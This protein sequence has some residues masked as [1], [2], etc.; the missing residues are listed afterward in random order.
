[1][2]YQHIYHAGNF[3]DVFKHCV[4]IALMEAFFQKSKPIT[5]FETH[6]GR[7][8]YDLLSTQAQKNP[9]FREGIEKLRDTSHTPQV[10]SWYLDTIKKL[11][12][13]ETLQKIQ[14]YPGSPYLLNERRRAAD[15]LIL[16]E[17]H[18]R[19]C[20]VLKTEFSGNTSVHV[21]CL[22]GYVGLKALLPPTHRRGIV[23]IDPPYEEDDEIL[24]IKSGLVTALERWQTATYVIWYPIKNTDQHRTLVKSIQ[25]LQLPMLNTGLWV[26][27]DPLSTKL[28]GSGLLIIN[29][30]WQFTRTARSLASWL[31]HYLSQNGQGD[32]FVKP[33]YRE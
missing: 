24:R 27:D 19:E 9:E 22:D 6:A 4:L 33:N 14:Y 2:N 25:S 5:Y 3:A 26:V 32:W 20:E 8:C 28:V 7:A 17:L 16:C 31:W 29:P 30:P 1:M 15:Q 10:V 18:P 21:H 11:N 13:T 12:Q 23:F